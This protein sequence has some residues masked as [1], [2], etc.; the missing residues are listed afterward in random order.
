MELSSH[1]P[2]VQELQTDVV[3]LLGQVSGLLNRAS[4]VFSSDSASEKYEK[5][6][7]EV[8]N[9]ARNV[10]DFEL[11][12]AIAAPM[13]AGKSTIINAIVGQEL[14]PSR[15]AAMTTIPT[16][17]I[18]EAGLTEPIL[19][20]SSQIWEVLQETFFALQRQIDELGIE[21]VLK[22]LG[23][24]PHL[25]TLA[26]KIAAKT[27]DASDAIP[28]EILGRQQI[29]NNLASL[30]DIIRLCSIIEP[31]ADPL[32]SLADVPRIYTP[33][34]RVGSLLPSNVSGSVTAGVSPTAEQSNLLGKL[35]IVDTP[36]PNEAGENLR[37]LNVVSDQL[38]KCS[39][40]LI[41][42]DFT[43]LKTRAAEKVKK[44][45]QRVIELRGNDN[46]YVLI[47]KVDQR[48]E[49][50]LT[51]LQVRQFVAAELGIGAAG[52][53]NQVF[54]ISARQAFCAANFIQEFEQNPDVA[55][56]TSPTARKLAQ[57]VFGIDWEEE[58]EE[59]TIEDLLQKAKRLWKKSGFAPFLENA[60]QALMAEAAP[61][62]I[63]SALNTARGRIVEL[64]EDAQ[65]RRLGIYEDEEKLRL[66]IE[67]LSVDLQNLELCRARLQSVDQI[68]TQL[69]H[70]LNTIFENFKQEAKVS[71]ATYSNETTANSGS[72]FINW[73]AQTLDL[74]VDLNERGIIEFKTLVDAER[75]ADIAV[76]YPEDR[77]NVLLENIRS[78]VSQQI[79]Q[80]RQELTYL[81]ELE[82]KPIIE[83]ARDRLNQSWNVDL[84]LPNPSF[85]SSE[86]DFSKPRVKR[87]IRTLG[88]GYEEKAVKTKK[89]WYWFGLIPKQEIIQVK[90]PEQREA[91]YTVSLQEIA[92]EVNKL[93]E[94]SIKNIKQGLNQYLE[95]DF[96]QRVDAFF[97]ELDRYLSNYYNSL[98]Q[99]QADQK[100][101]LD[102]KEKL[103]QE[104]NALVPE[105]IALLKQADTYLEAT[106]NLKSHQ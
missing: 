86:I 20:L 8:T 26:E 45:V 42:L 102:Q 1:Q 87:H 22:K 34:W 52:D 15:N 62:C 31:L 56:L 37:L 13:K 80:A 66:E 25:A 18:F 24:Y 4:T 100:L 14:L 39:L 21:R 103:V 6:Q 10:E 2:N 5:L 23:Q 54:E 44:H 93:I 98:R 36:G 41:V 43:Q 59:A 104:L 30:N 106:A 84:S 92:T 88:Q 97:D 58:L 96:Q 3:E 47:N 105:A 69:Y 63:M 12:M 64:Q 65:L 71:L 35:V 94:G 19:D 95:E 51:P 57:E 68:K 50:D 73:I 48:R 16:E 32:N 7:Q 38:E 82:T 27:E 17:I 89:W 99:A 75:F 74:T 33:F 61:R 101:S 28:R 76:A 49:G 40:V 81:L 72:D 79:E 29:V 46:L 77:A 91:Y 78:K 60:V 85:S 11:R 90:I 55:V 9:A 67:A 83:S 53:S 70:S